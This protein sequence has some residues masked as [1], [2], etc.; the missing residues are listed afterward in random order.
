[1]QDWLGGQFR[2]VKVGRSRR[3]SGQDAL[4]MYIAGVLAG[5]F[6]S[7]GHLYPHRRIQSSM[8]VSKN[9]VRPGLHPEEHLSHDGQMMHVVRVNC[10]LGAAARY[11]HVL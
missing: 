7:I 8:P 10:D 2:R 6:C 11:N 4:I 3:W 9:E 5:R 1:M